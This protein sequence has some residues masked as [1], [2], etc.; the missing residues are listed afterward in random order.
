M[1][2]MAPLDGLDMSYHVA[3]CPDCGFAFADRLPPIERY[4]QYYRSLSKYDIVDDGS[5]IS[6][7]ESI[8]CAAAV[9]LLRESVPTTAA[10]A[11]LGCG[12]GVLLAALRDA[13]WTRLAG[14]DPAPAAAAQARARFGIE[15]VRSGRLADAGS[16]LD[17]RQVDLVCLT[18][19]LEHLPALRQ[20]METLIANLAKRTQ[21]LVEV[22]ALER[23]AR[24]PCEP[25]GEFSL[26]H[27]Q[28]FS[29][30]SLVRF[31]AALGYVPRATR[32]VE[33]PA[34]SCDSLFGLF[35]R[36]PVSAAAAPRQP[37]GEADLAGYIAQS[38]AGMAACLAKLAASGNHPLVLYG[39]GSHTA[40]L[41]P[42]LP[43]S[44]LGRIA[45]ILD[46]NPNLHGKHLGR[47]AIEPATAL[48]AH[49]TA[50]VVVSAFRGR[51]AIAD[52]LRASYRNPVLS[53]Y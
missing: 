7:T 18:G 34:G 19:V 39:A 46:R 8:R 14:I 51:Q 42:R 29:T 20:D 31:L 10:I 32:I 38:E 17:L 1:N 9:T 48:A 43:E 44:V 47:F 11:D 36:P 13:G 50:T 16:L 26:E 28:Y 27:I 41:L 3:T 21:I 30:S 24:S 25:Y 22:P 45:S 6:P 12:S 15:T 37:S 23:F 52:A 5:G 40:R 35:V 4:D 53:L 49:P 33:L 2:T